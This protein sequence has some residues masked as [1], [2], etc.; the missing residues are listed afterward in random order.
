MLVLTRKADESVVIGGKIVVRVL[1]VQNGRVRL[2][3]E[4]PDEVVVLREEI[5]TRLGF[6]DPDCQVQ[7]ER[8]LVR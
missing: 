3:I 6:S 2:G 8:A 7:P 1:S 5:A 4:A